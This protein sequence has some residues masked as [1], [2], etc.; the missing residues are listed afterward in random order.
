MIDVA[1]G[2]IRRGDRFFLQRRLA[3]NP[4]LPGLWEFPG[5]KVETGESVLAAL[6]RE[7]LEEVGLQVVEA[8][9]GPPLEGRVRLHPFLLTVAGEPRTALAW[10]WFTSA[11]L[12]KLPIPA[13][14]LA[15]VA[16]L[17]AQSW[18]RDGG[19]P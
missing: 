6:Q 8:Q 19:C 14:N 10:G 3:S 5:G 17:R 7:L 15:L 18:P 4:V 9:P 12:L 11:E 13:D 1:L 2:L 16:F